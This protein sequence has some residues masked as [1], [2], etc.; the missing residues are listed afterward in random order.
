LRTLGVFTAAPDSRSLF[1]PGIGSSRWKNS[2][3]GI[4]HSASFVLPGQAKG[5]RAVIGR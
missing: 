5:L 4:T 2:M 3:L 1:T